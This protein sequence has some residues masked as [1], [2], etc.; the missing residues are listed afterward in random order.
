MCRRGVHCSLV[1]FDETILFQVVLD[2]AAPR[3]SA[4]ETELLDELPFKVM[5]SKC[6]VAEVD[7]SPLSS[8]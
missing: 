2:P 3:P 7:E 6:G 8:S 1:S 5:L 4:D